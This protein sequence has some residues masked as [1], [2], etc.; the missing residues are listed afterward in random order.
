MRFCQSYIITLFVLILI[1]PGLAAGFINSDTPTPDDDKTTISQ[2]KEI[3]TDYLKSKYKPTD[4]TV[5]TTDVTCYGSINGT[6]TITEIIGGTPPYIF[7]WRYEDFTLIPGETDSIITDLAPGKYYAEVRDA[8][9]SPIR[10]PFTIFEPFDIAIFDVY[11]TDITCNGDDD[12]TIVID[13][14]GGTGT[15]H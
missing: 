6:A 10:K 11:T 7:Q 1:P 3:F 14:I 12:G 13:A 5:T 4:I 15:L 9:G 2:H 8:D